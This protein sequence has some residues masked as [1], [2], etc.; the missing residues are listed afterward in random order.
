MKRLLLLPIAVIC[1]FAE[2]PA[3]HTVYILPMANG[4]DQY[5][6]EQ[7]TRDHVIQVVADPKIADA[8]IT[9]R[10]GE[11]FE[12]KMTQIHPRDDAEKKASTSNDVRP[13]FRSN[14]SR[15]NFFLVD[16]KS[17]QVLWSDYEKPARSL[18]REASKIAKKLGL[19]LHPVSPNTL[20]PASS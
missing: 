7:L 16:A 19:V 12:Q 9:D 11:A 14:S 2:V 17:R 6:A 4:L 15:E 5:L 8:I 3:V 10:L 18:N 20:K 13:A 1:A